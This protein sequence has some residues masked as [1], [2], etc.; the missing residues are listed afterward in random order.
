MLTI[1]RDRKFQDP[2]QVTANADVMGYAGGT[3][4]LKVCERP[5]SR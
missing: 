5:A 3:R 1:D 4:A 2:V